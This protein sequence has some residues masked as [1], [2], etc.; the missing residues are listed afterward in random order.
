MENTEVLVGF[1]GRKN[2]GFGDIIDSWENTFENTKS[3]MYIYTM[4]IDLIF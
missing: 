1:W 3:F 2:T 4:L